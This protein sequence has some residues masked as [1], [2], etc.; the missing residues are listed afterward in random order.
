M[1]TRRF[2]VGQYTQA[3]L[4]AECIGM[5]QENVNKSV[6][7]KPRGALVSL[8][9]FFEHHQ[10]LGTLVEPLNKASRPFP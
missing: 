4:R 8:V 6:G 1:Y 7:G 9:F 2:H 3:G 10:G 5:L